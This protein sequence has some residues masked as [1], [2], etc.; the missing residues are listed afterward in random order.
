MLPLTDTAIVYLFAKEPVPGRV[1]TRLSPP[2]TREQAADCYRAFLRDTLERIVEAAGVE[3]RVAVAERPAPF[4]E[5]LCAGLGLEL[6]EQG[7]GDLGQRMKRAME[8]HA[9]DRRGVILLAS[10]V[11]DLPLELLES[12]AAV[13]KTGRVVVGPGN[14][15]GYYLIGAS[16]G[17]PPVFDLEVAWGGPDVLGETL[18]R[19]ERAGLAVELLPEWADVDDYQGLCRLAGRISGKR[20]PRHSAALIA[21]LSLT[22]V[23]G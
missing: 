11:P 19:L 21:S 6:R 20:V 1:K 9:T 13:L 2:L 15:G 10:D 18:A 7:P 8:A 17:P 3:V 5:G 16:T 22:E 23:R 14:D 4:V 12:A